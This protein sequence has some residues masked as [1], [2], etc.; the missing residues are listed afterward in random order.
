MGITPQA[1]WWKTP[2]LSQQNI[3]SELMS[4]PVGDL[5][6]VLH[7]T[8]QLT[9]GEPGR[10]PGQSGQ[11]PEPSAVDPASSRSR[12]LPWAVLVQGEPVG[13]PARHRRP[14]LPPRCPPRR[15]PRLH[16]R[17]LQLP[18]SRSNQLT[19]DYFVMWL[20]VVTF[21]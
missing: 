5:V 7:S 2:N 21:L 14:P 4:N 1:Q 11:R 8:Q 3:V 17:G 9:E 16:H 12:T 18:T 20:S 15:P 10:D 6:V 13:G 19:F